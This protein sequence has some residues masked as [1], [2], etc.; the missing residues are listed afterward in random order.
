MAEGFGDTYEI[1]K[2]WMTKVSHGLP[3]KPGNQ[4]GLQ[5]LA[6]D[7]LHCEIGRL[8]QLGNEDGLVKIKEL[9]PGFVRACWQ[10]CSINLIGRKRSKC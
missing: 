1:L 6:D 8:A 9:C 2:L 7:L 10:N 5:E 3:I 4:E